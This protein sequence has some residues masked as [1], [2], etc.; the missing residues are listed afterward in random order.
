MFSLKN[1]VDINLK[2]AINSKLYKNYRVIIHCKTLEDKIEKKLQRYKCEIIRSIPSIGCICAYVSPSVIERIIEYPQVDYIFFDSYA[3]LCG[4]NS[5][6]SSNG[7]FFDINSKLSGKD[8]CVGIIDS[9]T[10]PH[11][12]LKKPLDKIAHFKDLLNDFNYPYDDNGH[13]TFVSGLICSNGY[14]SEGVYKGVAP[15]S[16]IYMVK[17]F[18]SASRGFI[19]DILFGID[20]L[21]N[22]SEEYGIKVI[23][24]P[25]EIVEYNEFVLSLFSRL[26]DIAVE[27][28]ITVVVPSGHN[29]NVDNSLTGIGLLK[30]CITVGGL[31]T[32]KGKQPY[33]MS[34]AGSNT[35]LEKPDLCAAC[36]DIC[37]L[38]CDV[39]YISER[40]GHKLYPRPLKEP[41]TFFT[42]TSCAC[43]YISG[44]CALLYESNPSLTYKDVSSLLKMSCNLLDMPKPIQGC[45]MVDIHKLFSPK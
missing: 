26:F 20:L 12:D 41:Y 24:L 25:F 38:N 30:N 39:N 7:I 42:G 17:A 43:A 35:K 14:S 4:N 23:C 22:E 27:K 36:V 31:D 29:G 2:N 33:I 19:S 37:S 16:K 8:V 34:S 15:R 3:F 1:K 21:I 32:T 40:N 44:I 13:G 9:G 18:N 5:I 45:G 6:L 11:A 10:Y 28:N